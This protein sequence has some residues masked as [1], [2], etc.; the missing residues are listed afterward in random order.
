MVG[1][2]KIRVNRNDMIKTIVWYTEKMTQ[3]FGPLVL[4]EA[5]RERVRIDFEN[6]HLATKKQQLTNTWQVPLKIEFSNNGT[7][8]ISILDEE[9]IL[10]LD[11]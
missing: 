9:Q 6:F 5:Q 7:Y 1:L 10:F 8:K 3:K 2:M 4:S 11:W